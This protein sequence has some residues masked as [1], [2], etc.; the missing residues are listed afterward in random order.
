M[1]YDYYC[2]IY[3][4]TGTQLGLAKTDMERH[5]WQISGKFFTTIWSLTLHN[6]EHMMQLLDMFSDP[7]WFRN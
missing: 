7:L 2:A 6:L 1:E 5:Y 3:D 4:C